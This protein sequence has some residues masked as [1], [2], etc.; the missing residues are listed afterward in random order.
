VHSGRGPCRERNCAL[1]LHMNVLVTAHAHIWSR[2]IGRNDPQCRGNLEN[3]PVSWGRLIAMRAGH[4]ASSKSSR[5]RSGA[6]KGRSTANVLRV[7]RRGVTLSSFTFVKS[8]PIRELLSDRDVRSVRKQGRAPRSGSG[9][10]VRRRTNFGRTLAHVARQGVFALRVPAC[11][12]QVTRDRQF[13]VVVRLADV[14]TRRRKNPV[15]IRTSAHG[16]PHV[17]P[18]L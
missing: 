3:A 7:D 11:I 12:S 2:N 9:R 5:S 17:T 8:Q 6:P 16:G 1:G 14:V 10:I 13:A 4:P 18:Y 15:T